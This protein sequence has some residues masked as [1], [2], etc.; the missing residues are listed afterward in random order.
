MEYSQ[1]IVYT[2]ALVNKAPLGLYN[3]NLLFAFENSTHYNATINLGLY[4]N[5]R[6]RALDARD[7]GSNPSNPVGS[8]GDWKATHPYKWGDV[9]SIPTISL[10][11][12]ISYPAS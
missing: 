10:V 11:E 9:G 3:W 7:D 4:V 1:S 2:E 5:G 6:L 8:E 12:K